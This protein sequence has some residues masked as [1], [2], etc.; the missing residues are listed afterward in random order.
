[1]TPG[2]IRTVTAVTPTATEER[3][4]KRAESQRFTVLP[5]ISDVIPKRH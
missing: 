3:R 5:Q 2:A 4:L 1:L